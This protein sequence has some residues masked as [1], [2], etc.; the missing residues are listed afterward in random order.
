MVFVWLGTI[1]FSIC[2]I[3]GEY[4]LIRIAVR[5]GIDSSSAADWKETYAQEQDRSS[6]SMPSLDSMY[7]DVA[8]T[9]S[10]KSLPPEQRHDEIERTVARRARKAVG[11]ARLKRCVGAV[12][13]VIVG[14]IIAGFM[15]FGGLHAEKSKESEYSYT[16][17]YSSY[18]SDDDEF[19]SNPFEDYL[20]ALDRAS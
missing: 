13:A 20:D 14:A 15:V 3:V 11:E 17:S 7:R 5:D 9:N 2:V 8:G 4:L 6:S 19:E 12:V 10:I 1:L 18:S 16:P